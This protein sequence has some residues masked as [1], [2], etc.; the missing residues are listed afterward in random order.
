LIQALL[1]KK[2]LH[3]FRLMKRWFVV[4]IDD[5]TGVMNFSQ[6]HCEHF[7]EKSRN[8]WKT[9]CIEAKARVKKLNHRLRYLEASQNEWKSKAIELERELAR[10]QALES[11]ESG[12]EV[13]KTVK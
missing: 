3:R 4:A 9:K 13:K 2:A 12:K 6:K 11:R 10:I 8:Q 7:F 1:E 5:G